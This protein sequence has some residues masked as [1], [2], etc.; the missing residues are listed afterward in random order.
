MLAEMLNNFADPDIQRKA[1]TAFHREADMLAKLDNQ[2]VPRVYDNFS[3]QNHHYLVMDYVEGITLEEKLTLSG[4][5]LSE[6][7]IKDICFG[8][9]C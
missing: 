3:E 1:A 6:D 5:R 2:H 8:R 7:S 9:H 4:R